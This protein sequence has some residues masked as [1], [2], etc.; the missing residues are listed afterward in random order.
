MQNGIYLSNAWDCGLYYDEVEDAD[1]IAAASAAG[2]KTDQYR[3][4]TSPSASSFN[5]MNNVRQSD[6]PHE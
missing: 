2:Y 3:T 4:D 6:I 5:Y 1:A